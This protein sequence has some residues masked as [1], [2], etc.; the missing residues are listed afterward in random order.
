MIDAL[1]KD[2]RLY[3]AFCF[4]TGFY[5]AN[6]TAVLFAQALG[7][8][9]SQIFTLT[10]FY[11]LMFILFEV[12]TGA[13]A[14]LIGRKKTIILGC[15]VLALGAVASGL[16]NNF[17]QLFSSYFLWACGF[18]L[19]SGASEALLYDRIADDKLFSQTVGKAAFFAILGTALA[20]IVGPY[21]F[22]INF[23]W[24]YFGSAIPFTLAAV[25]VGFFQEN[26]REHKGF[27]FTNHFE[28]IKA[29]VKISISNK[30]I[31][32]STGILALV[33]AISYT[34][35]N[36][37]QPY[38]VGIGFPVAQFSYILPV[39]FVVQA[40]GGWS[41][42]KLL[43]FGERKLFW[44]AMLGI[45]LSVSALGFFPMKTALALIF[46][47]MFMEGV[48]RPLVSNYANR[49]IDSAN[50]ATVI[51]VQSMIGS[52]TAAA[53]LFLIGFLTDRIGV[54]SVLIALG[55]FVLMAGVVLL[56]FRPKNVQ[57]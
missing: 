55:A 27:T 51:S 25:A 43:R 19:I 29:G 22:S 21:L 28:Q 35:S 52:M 18:S 36:T 42:G 26:Y 54:Y 15:V 49:Y 47:F 3:Y 41:F 30:F 13:L 16:S 9:Y 23:R 24:A 6:G 38:L 45:A 2:I 56:I 10:G 40:V 20:G 4:L 34:F 31:L 32:W 17:W 53:M 48:A 57:A 1:K 11:M 12:P 44:F 7:L 50:R 39:M 8:A 14:D 46:V 33:F 37:Y 5:V